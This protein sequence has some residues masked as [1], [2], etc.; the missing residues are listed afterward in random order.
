MFCGIIIDKMK[1]R[2]GLV[3]CK[4][5]GDITGF[6]NLGNINDDLSELERNQCDVTPKITKQMLVIMIRGIFFK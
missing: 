2:E 3:Y 6:C 5:T 4:R 1:I